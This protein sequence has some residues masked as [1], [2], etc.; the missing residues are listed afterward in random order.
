MKKNKIKNY[1][2]AGISALVLFLLFST[3]YMQTMTIRENAAAPKTDEPYYT[4]PKSSGI[5]FQFENNKGFFVYLDFENAG[6]IFTLTE[7]AGEAR[8]SDLPVNFTVK[9][10][11]DLLSGII[12]RVG[13]IEL[14]IEE[15]SL[16]Y[17]GEQVIDMLASYPEDRE[18]RINIAKAV[19]LNISKNGFSKNDFVYIIENSGTDLLVPD[20]F[21]WQDYISKAVAD[22]EVIP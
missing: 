7:N 17:T 6:S 4:G 3:V 12:D 20:C 2:F 11:Y 5:L 21:Y 9:S 13:G 16:R 14:K 19:F 22:I 15:E 18:L 10:D 1:I 8:I